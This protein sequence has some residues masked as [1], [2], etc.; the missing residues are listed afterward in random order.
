MASIL[1]LC[2]LNHLINLSLSELV[3]KFVL[4]IPE[5]LSLHHI[6]HVVKPAVHF[7]LLS[8]FIEGLRD[9]LDVALAL[10]A[11][12]FNTK[13]LLQL[14]SLLADFVVSDLLTQHLVDVDATVNCTD[15]A[16]PLGRHDLDLVQLLQELQVQHKRLPVLAQ[17][18]R[19]SGAL[20]KRIAY[21]FER[22]KVWG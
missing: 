2:R 4:L 16:H 22:E 14:E 1:L 18:A 12:N 7:V 20:L 17:L 9:D 3:L 13:L 6:G 10:L 11:F 5:L 8:E 15:V 19:L 21:E